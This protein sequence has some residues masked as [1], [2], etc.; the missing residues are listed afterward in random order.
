ML[1]Q[2]HLDPRVRKLL[3]RGLEHHQAGRWRPAEECYRRTLRI[4]PQC[5][6]AL[7]L[8]GLL[9]QQAG[10]YQ[11]SIR[12]IGKALTLNPDD[13][14]TLK[15]LGDSLLGSGQIRKAIPYL[16]RVTELLPNS[17]EARHRL[18]R[19]QEKAGEWDAAKAT[20]ALTLALQPDSADV[21]GSLA[22]LQHKQ[23]AYAEAV[24]SSRHA[25]SIDPI[26]YEIYT[27]LGIALTDLGDYAAAVEALRSALTLKPDSARAVYGLGY[28]FERKGDLASAVDAYRNALALDSGMGQAYFHLGVIH[29]LHGD[30]DKA[31]ECL[32][33][34]QKLEPESPDARSFRG[35]IHLQQGNFR[36]GWSEYE[37]RWGTPY[38]L[39]F[40]RSFPQPLWSGEPLNG[41]RI[42]L[43]AEQGMGDT[44][45]FVRYVA[46]V[47]ERGGEVFLE[48]QPRLH[49]LLVPLL[50][51]RRV[52]CRGEQ[53]P[54]CDWQCP[55]LSLPMAFSTEL[56]TIPAPGPYIHP[57]PAL[58]E[59]WRPRVPGNGLRI[60][61][62]WAGSPLHPNDLWRSIP[63]PVLTPLTRLKGVTFYS[64]QMGPP[65]SQ[66]KEIGPRM[67]LID[68]S[69]EQK[70]FA[71]T[72]AIVAHLDLVISVD[73]SVAHLA[74]A[75][76]EPVWVLLS[77]SPDWRWLLDREDSPWYSTARLFR[78]SALGNWHDVVAR[79]DRE[80]R[81]W[82]AMNGRAHVEGDSHE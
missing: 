62:A 60:G 50:G 69:E 72:A 17:V 37:N 61:L 28:F 64:L 59:A 34:L 39:R 10:R 8:L 55:L 71:D 30:L 74:G 7:H 41:S 15:S 12:L 70:D 29:H 26:N 18:G 32:E 63:L 13:A 81:E 23:G 24:E 43:H 75:M 19:A 66:V 78:Q 36:Q 35:L 4:N 82:V 46:L 1:K 80:L 25:L 45:Q 16:E 68:L 6:Q 31:L 27:Q 65:A 42:L 22:G 77:K 57:D 5:A 44:L 56:D 3:S 20:Y 52:L 14:D 38:G 54:E 11:E 40:R 73:T 67:E 58:V 79:V 51:A 2:L 9:A 48:V 33:L 49:R 53:P 47:A 21:Y 76:G